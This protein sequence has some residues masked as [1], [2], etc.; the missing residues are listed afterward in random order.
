MKPPIILMIESNGEA[1]ELARF[2]LWRNNFHCVLQWVDEADAAIEG[3][4]QR[5]ADGEM[6]LPGMI[7]LDP[8]MMEN[9]GLDFIQAMKAG[10]DTRA[11]PIVVFPDSDYP[12]EMPALLEAGAVEYLLKPETAQQFMEVV[13]DRA[14]RW[15]KRR[16]R[17]SASAST[18]NASAGTGEADGEAGTS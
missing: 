6:Q 5:R 4:L 13:L 18:S 12:P 16:R 14:R 15:S 17:R 9:N 2:A 8:G 11:V 1:V 3:L 10:R 7:F